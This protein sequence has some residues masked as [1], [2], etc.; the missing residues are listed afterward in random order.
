MNIKKKT[1]QGIFW[2][3]LQNWGSQAGSFII[4]LIL[5]RLLTPEAFGLVAL[6]NVLINFMQIFLNQGFAQV[7]IQK[8]DL[9]SQDINTVFWTQVF[10]GCLLTTIT[11]FSAILISK[12]FHQPS[13]IPILQILS[14]VFIVNAFSQTQASLLR[15][16]F[17]FKV[18][19][20]RS[21][22]GI[23]IAGIVGV[24]MAL[25]GYGVWSLVSQQLTYELMGVIVLWTASNWRPKWQFSWI[26]LTEIFSFSINVLG[27]K[28]VEFFNQKTDN[29]LVGYFLGE[30]ALGYYAISHR[31]LEVMTQLLIGTLNQVALPTF[32]RLQKDSQGFIAAYYRIT[33]F[34]SLIAFPVFFAVI[35]LSP[36]LVISLFG[37]KWTNAIPILQI[38]SL[39]GILRA[40]T[41]FQRSAFV[42][43]G[44]PLLQFKLGLLNATLNVIAC[45]I[46]VQ[47]G[48]LAVATAYVL[49][50]YLVFP[51]GQ[52]LLS[53]LIS[54]SWKT[55]LA[56][57]IAPITS[58]VIMGLTILITQQL[59]SPWLEPQGRLIICSLLGI[60]IYTATLRF[61]F[62]QLFSQIFTTLN[63]LQNSPKTSRK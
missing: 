6:A 25:L 23:I 51:L 30:V 32:S 48:I 63:L 27:Y 4:F 35:I 26:T 18:L 10:T 62:P 56:Q 50:D 42:S 8:Q 17:K 44:Q 31:I 11:F 3:G 19:A 28:M 7:L 58:T 54:L 43:L 47:W 2:S 34:T 52:W 5:A 59:L 20:T 24:V 55:Y 41:V 60:T 46:A 57:F 53:K 29:L 13:L 22:L 16:D 1:I 38:I 12:V 36:E 45:L 61:A 33:Q 40:I 15:R 14:L 37:Q 9:E 49:S 21:L 39:V